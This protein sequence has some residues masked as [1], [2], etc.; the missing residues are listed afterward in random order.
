M[1]Q[2][3]RYLNPTFLDSIKPKAHD[4]IITDSVPSLRFYTDKTSSLDI[5]RI[6]SAVYAIFW[7]KSDVAQLIIFIIGNSTT[8]VVTI[9]WPIRK[10]LRK[11]SPLAKNNEFLL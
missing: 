10:S 9:R 2:L 1:I 7:G 5:F 8:E 6:G 3:S 11:N 4:P